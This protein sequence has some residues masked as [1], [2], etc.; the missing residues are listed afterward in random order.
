MYLDVKVT[1]CV[2]QQGDEE[3]EDHENEDVK[4]KE[5]EVLGRGQRNNAIIANRTRVSFQSCFS[6][7]L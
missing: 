1:D 6:S 7:C 4:T 2:V 5:P 3:D